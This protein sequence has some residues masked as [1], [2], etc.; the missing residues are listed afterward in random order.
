MTIKRS[1]VLIS[2]L[3]FLLSA[4]SLTSLNY[5]LS[6]ESELKNGQVLL[7]EIDAGIL[8]LRRHEKDFLLRK[9]LKYQQKFTQTIQQTFKKI[10]QLEA[11][12]M[13]ENADAQVMTQLATVLKKYQASFNAMVSSYEEVGLDEK[14]GLQGKLRKAAHGLEYEAKE[15]NNLALYKDLLMLRRHEKDFLLRLDTKYAERFNQAVDV[16]KTTLQMEQ[17]DPLERHEISSLLAYYQTQFNAMVKGYIQAGLD[18]NSG[19]QGEMRE[20]VHQTDQVLKA[21]ETQIS[22]VLLSKIAVL[23]NLSNV[24]IT[25]IT[26]LVLWIT[27]LVNRRIMRAVNALKQAMNQ[28]EQSNDFS[29]RSS[30]DEQDEIG[31]IS[32][33]F[34]HLMGRL[35]YAIQEANTVVNAVAKGDFSQRMT[36]ALSGDLQTLKEGV[37]GSAKSVECMMNELEKVLQTLNDGQFDFK[38][39]PNVSEE[40]R[41]KVD[42]TLYNLHSAIGNILQVMSDVEQGNYSTRITVEAKGD[43]NQLKIAVNDTVE[44][45]EKAIEDINRV[46]IAQQNGDLTQRITTQYPGQLALLTQ[47]INSTNLKLLSVINDVDNTVVSISSASSEV[48]QRAANLTEIIKEQSI[49]MDE[50]SRTMEE[51]SSTVQSNTDNSNNANY[52]VKQ[53]Q[54]NAQAGQVVMQKTI[55]AMEKIQESSHKISDIV[56]LIDGIAFQT[57]LLALNAAV[58]AARAGEQGRGFAVVAGEVRSLAG[59]SAEAAKEIKQLIEESVDRINQGSQLASESG[60][61]LEEITASVQEVS[62]M[63]E[64]IANSSVE[65]AEAVSQVSATI[66]HLNQATQQNTALV[67][68]TSRSAEDMQQQ[69]LELKESIQFFNTQVSHTLAVSDKRTERGS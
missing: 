9:Q 66:S 50:T 65:Q 16:M 64:Y 14:S 27:I 35:Q 3:V 56:S 59:K 22:E 60:G 24:V 43:L 23:S 7:A 53:V 48:S 13:Q 47:A 68:E 15:V 62:E 36:S 10:Q 42:N 33:A 26:V 19:L 2:V 57:N 31:D 41:K 37:N 8:M 18:S 69:A 12:L 25:V 17:L 55:G 58:E 6:K 20:T 30:Y 49:A 51:M 54:N 28:T 63:I 67:H 11:L 29:L 45:L 40:F 38:M 39:N 44:S 52:A 61:V 1:M 46:V 21:T 32:R 4:I 5:S 34:N